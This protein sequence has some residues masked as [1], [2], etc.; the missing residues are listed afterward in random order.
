LQDKWCCNFFEVGYF[1][2]EAKHESE[3]MQTKQQQTKKKMNTCRGQRQDGKCVS[4]LWWGG[5]KP[6]A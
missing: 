4:K 2:A 5:N 6:L 1:T 3:A